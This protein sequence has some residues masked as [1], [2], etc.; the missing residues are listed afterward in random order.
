V[1]RATSSIKECGAERQRG[2]H[3][4]DQGEDRLLAGVDHLPRPAGGW[5]VPVM[6]PGAA[7][8]NRPPNWRR[9]KNDIREFIM[10]GLPLLDSPTQ[11]LGVR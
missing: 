5:P 6:Q 9:A 7:P 3:E 1:S 11:A 2:Q 4:T 10:G 8:E